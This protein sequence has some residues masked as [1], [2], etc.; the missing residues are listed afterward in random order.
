MSALNQIYIKTLSHI[1][2]KHY[3]INTATIEPNFLSYFK[4]AVGITTNAAAIAAVKPYKVYIA[5]LNQSGTNAPVA[6]VLEN[7]LGG[8]EE[9]L[10][11]H[12]QIQEFMWLHYRVLLQ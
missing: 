5:L 4:D 11:G 3:S 2:K 9:K 7:T 10:F 6:I 8:G 12:E 1:F